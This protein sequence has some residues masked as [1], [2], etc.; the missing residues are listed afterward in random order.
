[1]TVWPVSCLG[2]WWGCLAVRLLVVVLLWRLCVVCSLPLAGPWFLAVP[3]LGCPSLLGSVSLF[4]VR[5]FTACVGRVSRLGVLP[6]F[7]LWFC[8]ASSRLTLFWGSWF[9]AVLFS[10]SCQLFAFSDVHTCQFFAFSDLK[11]K[12]HSLQT[13]SS[14]SH[15]RRAT[16]SMLHD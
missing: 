12:K 2:W 14:V 10:A 3:S 5:P 1:M 7:C 4:G 11:K 9:S 13:T 15:L 8:C 16:H 6:S